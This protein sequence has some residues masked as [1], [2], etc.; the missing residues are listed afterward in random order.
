MFSS[1]VAHRVRVLVGILVL[2][3][4]LIGIADSTAHAAA[5]DKQPVGQALPTPTFTPAPHATSLPSAGLLNNSV[6]ST[7][8]W[9]LQIERIELRDRVETPSK[10]YRPQN[11][12]FLIVVGE[13]TNLTD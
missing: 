13:L 9:R 10:R 11:G 3:L 7:S 5:Q 6:E 8:G 1:I 12:V 4:C 2:S